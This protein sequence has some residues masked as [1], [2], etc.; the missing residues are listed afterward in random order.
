MEGKWGF[1]SVR[2]S[3]AIGVHA[4]TNYIA[5]IRRP[6][7]TQHGFRAGRVKEFPLL[8][9]GGIA[10]RVKNKKPTSGKAES[11]REAA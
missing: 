3:S 8:T 1:L 7:K 9:P 5:R 10:R 11:A 2:S 6:S 4:R